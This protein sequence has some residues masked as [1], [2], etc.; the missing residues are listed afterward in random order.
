MPF[1]K[2]PI[3][4][5]DPARSISAQIRHKQLSDLLYG[6][7]NQKPIPQKGQDWSP[8]IH[9]KRHISILSPRSESVLI[10]EE[11]KITRKPQAEGLAEGSRWFRASDTTGPLSHNVETL[12]GLQK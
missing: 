7:A 10:S 1:R 4:R 2:Y 12:K 5:N 9:S 11:Q 8:L 6:S 3:G